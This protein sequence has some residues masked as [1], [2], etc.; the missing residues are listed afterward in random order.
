MKDLCPIALCN[1]LYK[2]IAKVLANRL[3]TLLP[4][5]V[6]P[7]KSAFVLGRLI[8]DSIL[9]AFELIHYGRN[10][11]GEAA[12]KIDIRMENELAVLS[13]N[14][15]ENEILQIPRDPF[16]ARERELYL[17]GCFL[18]ASLIHFP[19]MKSTMANLWHSVRGVQIQD[20]GEKRLG[21]NDSFC[22]AKMMLGVEVTDIGI[23][24][25]EEGERNNGGQWNRSKI[26]RDGSRE[27]ITIGK[28]GINIDPILGFNLEWKMSSL[29]Q[30]RRNVGMDQAQTAMEYDLEQCYHQRRREEEK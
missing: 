23:W 11:L 7:L 5:I 29:D 8:T 28:G 15:E 1:V 20:L 27:E 18:T 17:V 6:S 26:L 24:L 3:K 22:D 14:D 30:S 25:R 19:V 13:L 9:V 2:I 4:A 21:H 10:R 12:L 16:V